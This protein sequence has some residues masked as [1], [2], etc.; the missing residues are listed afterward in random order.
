MIAVTAFSAGTACMS[1]RRVS[2][3][4]LG[5]HAALQVAHAEREQGGVVVL[6]GEQGADQLGRLAILAI[7]RLPSPSGAL[8]LA[9]LG[10]DVEQD[11]ERVL[12]VDLRIRIDGD[13]LAQLWLALAVHAAGPA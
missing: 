10:L 11:A 4:V 2:D 7:A 9:E 1:P 6:A 13:D 5:G 8:R 12:Q 3:D